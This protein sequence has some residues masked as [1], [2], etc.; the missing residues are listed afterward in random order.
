MSV[1]KA[2]HRR[3]SGWQPVQRSEGMGMCQLPPNTILLNQYR[4]ARLICSGCISQT[5]LAEDQA[6]GS[7]VIVKVANRLGVNFTEA[8]RHIRREAMLLRCLK[9]HPAFPEI[10]AEGTVAEADFLVMSYVDGPSLRQV[11]AQRM[12]TNS[13]LSYE[14]LYR[15]A[16]DLLV[17]LDFAHARHVWHR[18]LKPENVLLA[19]TGRVVIID[20]GLGICPEAAHL[21]PDAVIGTPGYMCPESL[22]WNEC[23]D[24]RADLYALGMMLYELAAGQHP[25]VDCTALADMIRAQLYKHLPALSEIRPDLPRQFTDCVMRL[26]GK[27]PS[28][29]FPDA[30]SALR[31]L[32]STPPAHAPNRARITTRSTD[33]SAEFR[34]VGWAKEKPWGQHFLGRFAVCRLRQKQGKSSQAKSPT[35]V[36]LAA[37]TKIS[38]LVPLAWMSLR[39]ISDPTDRCAIT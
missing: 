23:V 13:P 29:R 35:N 24:H 39:P 26:L 20:L 15:I 25:F 32:Q 1:T 18:D 17:A 38:F 28:A 5:Y 27:A 4:V 30:R 31:A 3:R 34:P 11:L 8:N 9:G 6:S 33:M 36:A 22:R 14:A 19:E 37:G 12:E 7:K 2:K 10:L 16:C 21:T